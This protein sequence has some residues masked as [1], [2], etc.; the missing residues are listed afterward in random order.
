MNTLNLKLEYEWR[1][2]EGELGK[3]YRFPNALTSHLKAQA[4]SPAVYR[5]VIY[6]EEPGDL[7]KLYIGETE[8]LSRRIYH[9]LKPGPSQQTN[10]RMNALFLEE[11]SRGNKVCLDTLDFE[12]FRVN[13]HEVTMNSLENKTIRRFVE[14][15]LAF[16]YATAGD[17]VFNL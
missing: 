8:Q 11:I 1:P 5:W 17:E 7:R 15:L 12:P 3:P 6:H 2:V 14:H 10:L 13:D 9:Y 4:A 16:Q